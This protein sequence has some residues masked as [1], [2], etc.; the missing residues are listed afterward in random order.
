MQRSQKAFTLIELLV[1]IA[2]IAI[3]AAIL[4]PVFAQAKQAAKKTTDLSNM[5]QTA[6]GVAIYLND[7]DDNYPLYQSGDFSNWPASTRLWSSV[8]VLGPYTKNYDLLLSPGDPRLAAPAASDYTYGGAGIPV[9]RPWHQLSYLSN[10]FTNWG[11]HRKYWGLDSGSGAV[12]VFPVGTSE[13]AP[14]DSPTSATAV[15]QPSGVIM[16][17]NGLYDYYKNF[18]GMPSGCLDNEIDYCYAFKAVYDPFQTVDAR[19]AKSSK[20]PLYGMWRQ[21]SGRSNFAF[22]DTHAK[23]LAPEAVDQPSY[24]LINQ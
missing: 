20:D 19:L 4:F 11:D 23:S 9:S 6:T 17:A 3:L 7:F 14:A 12:G 2:I 16:F 21:F 8:L 24:W 18:Y 10:S 5:K 1:V 13:G 22:T 15:N